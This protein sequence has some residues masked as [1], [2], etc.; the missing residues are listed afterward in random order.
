MRVTTGAMKIKVDELITVLD[1]DIELLKLNLGRLDSLRGALI[2]RDEEAM[3]ELLGA[4]KGGSDTQ[5]NNDCRRERVRLELAGLF[6]CDARDL[7]VTM[8]ITIVPQE[9]SKR[10][11]E[12]KSQLLSLTNKVNAEH[13]ST[14]ML[15]AEY[16]KLN[17]LFLKKIFASD[18]T[19]SL[20]YNS[21]GSVKSSD[22]AA[23]M[24]LKF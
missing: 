18:K 24:N 15:L 4:V 1:R 2:K 11:M 3:K 8:L 16:A 13:V 9:Q 19:D 17:R 23:F 12:K 20:V 10:L 14:S 5:V 21:R 22:D 6:G 7:T